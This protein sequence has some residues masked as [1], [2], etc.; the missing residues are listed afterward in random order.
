L[1]SKRPQIRFKD[2][3]D[4]IEAIE[5]YVASMN[6]KQFI[7]DQKSVDAVER[8]LSRISEAASKLGLLAEELAPDQPWGDIRGLGNKLRHEY[9]LIEAAVLWKT[10]KRD[11]PSLREASERAIAGIQGPRRKSRK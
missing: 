8:C 6:E 7:A 4:N 10:I 1:P 9:E 5:R 11:L 3:I 2:I